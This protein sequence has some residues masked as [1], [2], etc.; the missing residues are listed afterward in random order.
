MVPLNRNVN[1]FI[2]QTPSKI[3]NN[4]VNT[5]NSTNGMQVNLLVHC[6]LQ[7]TRLVLFF[8]VHLPPGIRHGLGIKGS[9]NALQISSIQPKF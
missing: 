4:K 1:V 7:S 9:L 3:V 8:M 5:T 2:I 6:A